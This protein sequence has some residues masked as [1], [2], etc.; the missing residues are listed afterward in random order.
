MKNGMEDIV[1]RISIHDMAQWAPSLNDVILF[2]E[3]SH[4]KQQVGLVCLV[5]KL[6]DIACSNQC[7]QRFQSER[8]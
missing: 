8:Y 6:D 1:R 7:K 2:F 4:N 5:N 3:D